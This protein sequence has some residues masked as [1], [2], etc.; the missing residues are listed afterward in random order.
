MPFVTLYLPRGLDDGALEASMREITDVGADLLENTLK[1]MIR[2]TIW[3]A[4]PERIYEG[5]KCAQGLYPVVLFRVGPGRSAQAKDAFMEQIAEILHK[6]LGC[7]KEN[8]RALV[9]DNEKGHHFCIG[10]KP[11]DFS[12]KVK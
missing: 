4:E 3:E 2:V 9:L 7:P 6:N 10:G 8:V 5:G 12:K 11:K 1:R